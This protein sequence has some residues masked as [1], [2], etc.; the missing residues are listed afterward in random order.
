[1]GINCPETK[2]LEEKNLGLQAKN[3]VEE[4]LMNKT[5][6]IQFEGQDK[7]GRTLGKIQF[8]NDILIN[9]GLAKHYQGGKREPWFKT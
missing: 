6:Y 3:L 2:N 4:K 9:K 8:I 7:P 1:M 5:L